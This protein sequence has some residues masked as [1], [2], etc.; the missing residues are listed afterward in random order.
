MFVGGVLFRFS[1][2]L[3]EFGRVGL[4]GFFV[5]LVFLQEVF[6]VVLIVGGVGAGDLVDGHLLDHGG[7][8]GG[9][10]EGLLIVGFVAGMSG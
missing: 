8:I 9:A 7:E 1:G 2:F 4:F 3:V 6:F 5:V 10:F